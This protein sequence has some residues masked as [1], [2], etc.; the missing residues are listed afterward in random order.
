MSA[1]NVKVKNWQIILQLKLNQILITFKILHKT[2]IQC[3]DIKKSFLDN[4]ES[5]FCSLEANY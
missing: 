3:N 2:E 4:F 1:I 5:I